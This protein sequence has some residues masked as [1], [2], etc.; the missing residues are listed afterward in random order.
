MGSGYAGLL[1][2]LL[3]ETLASRVTFLLPCSPPLNYLWT[4]EAYKDRVMSPLVYHHLSHFDIRVAS[5]LTFFEDEFWYV[6][7]ASS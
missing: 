3:T 5:L 7:E 6:R 2:R 1:V 4:L